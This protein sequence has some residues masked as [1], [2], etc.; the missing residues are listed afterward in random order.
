MVAYN[1]QENLHSLSTK[2]VTRLSNNKE[3]LNEKTKFNM[4]FTFS[5]K[6]NISNETN[7]C[8]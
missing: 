3:S 8:L 4:W 2:H 5:D 6:L 7:D 1:F